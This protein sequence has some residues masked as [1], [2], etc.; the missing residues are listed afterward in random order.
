MRV[1][2]F[3]KQGSVIQRVKQS[4]GIVEILDNN[5]VPKG[6]NKEKAKVLETLRRKEDDI[7]ELIG[8][9]RRRDK[10]DEELDIDNN[11]SMAYIN[12]REETNWIILTL[13]SSSRLL[14]FPYNNAKYTNG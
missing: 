3:A 4:I 10:F 14:G 11:D 9:I 7:D 5:K 13:E 1:R 12:E 2:W 6:Y 8:E